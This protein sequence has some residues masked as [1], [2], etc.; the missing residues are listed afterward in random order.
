MPLPTCSQWF[1]TEWPVLYVPT[2]FWLCCNLTLTFECYCGLT[3][4]C[5]C[6]NICKPRSVATFVL[7]IEVN[8]MPVSTDTQKLF[9]FMYMQATNFDL[10]LISIGYLDICTCVYR[11]GS[12]HN[13]LKVF[14]PEASS[15][16]S[17][18]CLL[19]FFSCSLLGC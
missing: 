15:W 1:H 19:L 17:S 13:K 3:R 5:S 14:M 2:F 8:F 11:L 12:V 6:R 9:Y 10:E 16:T 4:L 18:I 7:H